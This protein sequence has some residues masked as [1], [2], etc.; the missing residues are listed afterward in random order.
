MSTCLY[1]VKFACAFVLASRC[2]LDGDM[3][4]LGA[5]RD[6]SVYMDV[7]ASWVDWIAM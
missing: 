6:Q 1:R 3:H 5:A 4:K 2:L 7:H